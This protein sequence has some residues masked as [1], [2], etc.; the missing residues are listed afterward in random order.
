MNT[1]YIVM[2]Y[3]LTQYH[4]GST[5]VT[6]FDS[7]G[8][9]GFKSR[10]NAFLFS[11]VAYSNESTLLYLNDI[12]FHPDECSSFFPSYIYWRNMS[13]TVVSFIIISMIKIILSEKNGKKA[14]VWYHGY[15]IRD[16]VVFW[17]LKIL[18]TYKRSCKAAL[19]CNFTIYFYGS[20]TL[21]AGINGFRIIN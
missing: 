4:C 15:R 9:A 5:L 8:L 11:R 19:T 13:R 16:L 17:G 6:V 20:L 14:D 18:S 3:Y 7:V 1:M 21:E 10:V 12:Q 2:N